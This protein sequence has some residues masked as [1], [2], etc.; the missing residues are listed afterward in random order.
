MDNALRDLD[1]GQSL[2]KRVARLESLLSVQGPVGD[3][4][5][6]PQLLTGTVVMV[7][8]AALAFHG[9][10]APNHPYQGILAALA[11]ALAYHRRW[12]AR[13]RPPAIFALTAAANA[14]SLAMLLKLFIGGGVR[15]PL[16][17]AR[18]PWLR[19][20][21]AEGVLSLLP[22][23]RLD[24]EPTALATLQVDF[25]VLQTFLLIVTLAGA[26]FRFQPFVSL[27]ALALIAVSVPAFA[28]FDWRWVFPALLTA[29]VG[30]YLQCPA[31][32]AR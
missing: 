22:E 5:A 17:W 31:S 4:L 11:I 15:E 18:Y 7:A 21:K 13:P 27:T 8:A 1:A 10:G 16:S 14:A 25:T 9:L 24:W 20:S 30:L 29:T 32:R 3:Q 28:A 26:L 2:E 23:W 12:L 19:L 6:S